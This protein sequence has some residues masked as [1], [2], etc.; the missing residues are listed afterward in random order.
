VNF[1]AS[2]VITDIEG[3]T[4]PIAFVH[5]VLFP[6]ARRRLPAYV[7]A[8]PDDADVLQA[9]N[10]APDGDAASAL[11]AWMDA[12][13][14][15][16]PLKSL[17]GRIWHDGYKRGELVAKLYPDVA[18]ALR[19]W[20]ASGARL[21]V[22]SSGS[23]EAQRLL[24]GHSADGDLCGLF[25]DFFDTTTGAKREAASYAAIAAA[26]GIPAGACLFLSD[27]EAELDAARR[28]SMQTCQLVRPEDG[29]RASATHPHVADFAAVDVV[30]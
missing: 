2:A 6:Y 4:T 12:D 20:H 11:L 3:T 24:F 28:A 10:L 25:S 15:L 27:V 19:R 17:Q 9:G 13:A 26:T 30:A 14:K 18:P 1:S 29:T 22:Y 8:H 7:A 5:D 16:T 21:F 23:V